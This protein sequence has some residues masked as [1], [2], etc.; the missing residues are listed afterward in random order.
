MSIAQF[1]LGDLIYSHDEQK[2]KE[3][4]S[5]EIEVLAD[6]AKQFFNHENVSNGKEIHSSGGYIPFVSCISRYKH[7]GFSEEREV[8]VVALPTL[9]D[10]EMT[11]LAKAAGTTLKPEKVRKFRLNKEQRVPYIKIFDSADVKLPIEKYLTGIK[12]PESRNSPDIARD[13]H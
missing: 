3:E 13:K 5:D 6:I 2:L 1:L 4:L 12:K 7:F 8:R 10:D 11:K 9:V